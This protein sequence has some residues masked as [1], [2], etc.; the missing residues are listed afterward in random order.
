MTTQTRPLRSRAW[1]DNPQNADMTVPYLE[2]YMNWGLS[3]EELQSGKP[4]IRIAQTGSDLSPCNRH[5]L[6]PETRVRDG[7]IAAEGYPVPPDQ[8]PWH[9]VYPA[10]VLQLQDG[11]GMRGAED[12]GRAAAR[13]EIP[14]D[15][16]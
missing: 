7:I 15:S 8:T 5:H 14:R 11:A 3:F 10:T 9:R 16:H 2:R 1:F 13:N 12:F 6:T 4:N